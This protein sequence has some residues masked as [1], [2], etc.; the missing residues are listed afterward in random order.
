MKPED[1]FL[2]SAENFCGI[3]GLKGAT[4]DAVIAAFETTTL[5]ES[6]KDRGCGKNNDHFIQ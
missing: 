2:Q 4:S 3:S 5:R 6:L 1:N